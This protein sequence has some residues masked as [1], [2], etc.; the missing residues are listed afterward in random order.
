VAVRAC[1]CATSIRRNVWARPFPWTTS[2]WRITELNRGNMVRRRGHRWKSGTGAHPIDRHVASGTPC[3]GQAFLVLWVR[4]DRG[5]RNRVIVPIRNEGCTSRTD[6]RS[7]EAGTEPPPHHRGRMVGSEIGG[8]LMASGQPDMK[9][10]WPILASPMNTT[11]Q[12]SP[13]GE[14]TLHPQG[15]LR[16]GRCPEA[17]CGGP[18]QARCRAAGRNHHRFDTKDSGRRWSTSGHTEADSR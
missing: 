10:N 7:A 2:S 14:E 13:R 16:R 6:V 5:A 17:D 12:G 4:G 8:P 1:A 18:E 9:R 11:V 15:W 3:V